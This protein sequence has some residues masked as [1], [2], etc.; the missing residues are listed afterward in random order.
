ML[1]IKWASL[2]IVPFTGL[3]AVGCSDTALGTFS[4]DEPI[5]EVQIP[6]IGLAIPLPVPI[7]LQLPSDF[8]SQEELDENDFDFLTFVKPRQ[9]ELRITDASEDQSEDNIEDGSLDDFDFLSSLAVSISAAGQEPVLVASVPEGDPQ[10]G[11]GTRELQLTLEDVDILDYVEAPGGYALSV[12][13]D[14]NT[15]PDNV[16][17]EGDVSFR[18]GVG[19]R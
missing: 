6:S 3:L 8:T 14:G 10:Y 11:S 1:N 16:I 7:T 19:F 17:I 5:P 2:I 13:V 12:T 9:L 18:V 15:P 4:V